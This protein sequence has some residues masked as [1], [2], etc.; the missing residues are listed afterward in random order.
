MAATA[1]KTERAWTARRLDIWHEGGRFSNLA[2]ALLYVELVRIL[3]PHARFSMTS[4][5]VKA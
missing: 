5:A 1:R 3:D 2:D 4:S